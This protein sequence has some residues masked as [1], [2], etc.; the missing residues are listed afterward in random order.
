MMDVIDLFCGMGGLSYGFSSQGFRV[1]G[2]DKWNY[3]VLSFNHNRIGPAIEMDL[4]KYYPKIPKECIIIGGPPC[5]PWSRLN[6]YRWRRGKRHPLYDCLFRF[7]EFVLRSRPLLFVMENVPDVLKDAG[8]ITVM[9]KI[10]HYYSVETRVISYA[11]Y[12]AATARRRLFVIGVRKDCGVTAHLIFDEIPRDR[13][14]SVKDAIWDLR[15]RG[16]DD[17]IDHVWTRVRSA[18]RYKRYYRTGK[19]GWYVLSW[20]RPSPSFGNITKTYILHPD[21]F[22]GGE[23]RPISVREALRIMGF[24]DGYSFPRGI[25]MTAKYEMVADTVSP[26]FSMKLARTIRKLIP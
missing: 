3:A 9:K 10:E 20:D 22:N 21:S 15:S 16:W 18:H 8:M 26:V 11:D 13:P 17:A 19:Y 24:P 7:F 5:E 6:L 14:K 2:F 1:T 4:L 23:T 25:S 12:G